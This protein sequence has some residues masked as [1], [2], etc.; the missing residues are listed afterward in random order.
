MTPADTQ[1][2]EQLRY[3]IPDGMRRRATTL[4]V[5]MRFVGICQACGAGLVLFSYGWTLF[6]SLPSVLASLVHV[7]FVPLL[8]TALVVSFFGML[9]HQALLLQSAADHLTDIGDEP[10]DAHDHLILAFTRLRRVFVID[11]VLSVLILAKS[12]LKVLS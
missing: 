2:E 9:L 5:W 12:L 7:D 8:L 11:L 4:G 10:E 3:P 6:M 1:A